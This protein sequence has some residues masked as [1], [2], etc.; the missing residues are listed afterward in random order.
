MIMGMDRVSNTGAAKK[1]ELLIVDDVRLFLQLTKTIFSTEEYI[2]HT[3]INGRQAIDIATTQI[4]DL[5]LLD[6]HMPEIGGDEVCR[7]IR[8]GPSTKHIP[9]IMVTSKS[10][11]ETRRRCLYA[12]C[13]D[14]MTKPV[15]FDVL[16]QTVKKKLVTQKRNY[17]RIDV[18]LPC[19]LDNGQDRFFTNIHTLSAGGAYVEMDPPPLPD[20]DHLLTFFLPEERENIS[21]KALA[22]W[23][24]LMPG[25]RPAGSGFEF[26]NAGQENSRRLKNWAR[27]MENNEVFS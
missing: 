23:N 12:G 6:L 13:D 7:Q 1:K 4:P 27:T 19:L 21:V 22:R 16:N 11:E 26:V 18:V 2:I 10:D 25:S 8:S 20:S 5:I 17:P 14:F 15:R 3:A 24:R 9:V